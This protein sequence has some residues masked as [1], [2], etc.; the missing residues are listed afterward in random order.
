MLRN[1]N[2]TN[3]VFLSLWKK[4]NFTGSSHESDTRMCSH[5]VLRLR[6]SDPIDVK[7]FYSPVSSKLVIFL[8]IRRKKLMSTADSWKIEITRASTL[9]FVIFYWINLQVCEGFLMILWILLESPIRT[10]IILRG[11]EKTIASGRPHCLIKFGKVWNLTVVW[12]V[13]NKDFAIIR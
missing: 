2:K 10:R 5:S 9:Y 3:H 4:W 13:W 12:I 7:W 6:A 8:R 11:K 1:E